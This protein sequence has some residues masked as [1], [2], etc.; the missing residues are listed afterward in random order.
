LIDLSTENATIREPS[1][2][3]RERVAACLIVQNEQDRLPVALASVA[4]CDEIIVVDGGSTDRTVEI[5][6]QAGARV[7]E[8]PW[9]GYARQR[10]VAIDA[11]TCEWVLEVDADERVSPV[12]RRSIEALLAK[13]G[14]GPDIAVCALRNRFLGG[15]LGPSAKY[16]AYRSRLFRR[17]VYRHDQS[18]AVHEGLEKAERPTILDGN[19]EHE[20]AATMGEALSDVWSYARLESQHLRRPTDPGAYVMGILLRP[21]AKIGYRIVIDRGW[22]DGWRGL[23]KIWLDATS[24]TLVWTRVLMRRGR[25]EP[26]AAPESQAQTT[27]HGHFG[28]RAASLPKV[29]ALADRGEATQT[30]RRWL[31]RLHEEGLDVTLVSEEPVS[32]AQLP[33]QTVRH[34][35]PLA[36]MRIIDLEMQIQAIH[37]VVPFGRRAHL[38]SRLLPGSL[39][40]SIEGLSS[41]LDPDGALAA[42]RRASPPAPV[43]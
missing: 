30:A 18:R 12:L 38:V 23:L 37:A 26:P 14:G 11:S 24:D 33:T 9:P 10:N 34:L 31:G 40:P 6:R 29:V 1:S 19:L 41:D 22:R 7:I 2:G 28:R 27:G 25:L 42:I 43:S 32:D 17:G 21:L 36:V 15:V 39:R 3:A 5:A 35:R 13:R 20:L 16:P 4:F 8:N